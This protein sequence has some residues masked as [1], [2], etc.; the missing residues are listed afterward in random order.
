MTL[1]ERNVV[2]KAGIVFAL[3]CFIFTVAGSIFAFPVYPAFESARRSSGIAQAIT[4]RFLAPSPYVPVVSILAAALYA[5][6]TIILICYYFEK[7]Q[8][9]EILFIALFALSFSFEG[10]RLMTPLK[11]VREIPDLYLAMASRFMLF[12]RYFGIF[13]LF[14]ASV[15]AAGLEMQKQQNIIGV[16]V[17]VT[18]IIALRVPIDTLSWDSSFSMINGYRP[19]FRMID[20]G[21]LLIT[22]ASFFISAYSRGAR[23]YIFIGTGSLM[24]FAGRSIL[25]GADT[26]ISP[27]PGVLLL[28]LGTW[29]ICTCLHKVYLWL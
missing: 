26:W 23:E 5:L 10:M 7:T 18:L 12:G 2:F 22:M 1:Q 15:C 11:M 14:A 19:M 8:C 27:L 24:V 4:G 28:A 25:L 17:M 20:A 9:P 6:I 16:I 29:F 3:A 13:S 21:V